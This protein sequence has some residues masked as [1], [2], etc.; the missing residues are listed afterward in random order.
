[1]KCFDC[2]KKVIKYK[3]D[4]TY[5]HWYCTGCGLIWSTDKELD[6]KRF[7]DSTYSRGHLRHRILEENVIKYECQ[8][9]GMENEWQEKEIVLQLDHINGD[10]RDNRIEN[11]RFLCPNCHSQT[12]NWSGRKD[13]KMSKKCSCGSIINKK[14]IHCRSC[15]S[16]RQENKIVWPHV[17][18][19]IKMVE[20]SSFVGV[21]KK[22]GVTDSAIRKRIKN[23]IND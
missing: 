9:C 19:L 23:H 15:A 13:K 11:L 16:K 4:D 22:L 20:N 8:M 3:V 14:S 7:Q 5:N 1:M 2:G 6:V 18:E 12:K 10:Y 21:A 17:K